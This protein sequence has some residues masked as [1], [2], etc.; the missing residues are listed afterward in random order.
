[1]YLVGQMINYAQL[2]ATNPKQTHV[3]STLIIITQHLL[4]N[5]SVTKI[6]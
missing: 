4:F 5:T 2:N 1:M 3:V 6:P